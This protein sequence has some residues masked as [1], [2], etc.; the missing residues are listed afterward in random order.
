M[1]FFNIFLFLA[2]TAYSG[3]AQTAADACTSIMVGRKA[4]ADGSV[5]TSHTCDSW[6][7]TWM[8]MTEPKDYP[9]DTIMSIYEGRMHT[10]YPTSSDGM[11]ETGTSHL[12]YFRHRISLHERAS[13]RYGRD[14][15]FGTRYAGE[16]K[17][18]VHD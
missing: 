14:Y 15:V 5:I 9:N 12:P 3:A 8:Q 7:R 11:K 13:A 10:E 1:K 4:S 17:R 6:Y 16:Q 18:Y 2:L